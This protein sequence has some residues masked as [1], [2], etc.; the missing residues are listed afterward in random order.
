MWGG[1]FGIKK[2]KV[3]G[4][5]N[6]YVYPKDQF[7][8]TLYLN[9]K[10]VSEDDLTYLDNLKKEYGTKT[11]TTTTTEVET[12]AATTTTT[13]EKNGKIQEDYTLK[14]V[15][16][17]HL[18]W[19]GYASEDHFLGFITGY[20][21]PVEYI[22]ALI[23]EGMTTAPD[24]KN[25][26]ST[27]LMAVKNDRNTILDWAFTYGFF[28]EW[29]KVYPEKVAEYFARFV[30]ENGAKGGG[31]NFDFN[32]LPAKL[33]REHPDLIKSI[34]ITKAYTA[35]GDTADNWF[36]NEEG[37]NDS[38]GI[39]N[40]A[41]SNSS[42]SSSNFK[43]TFDED[44]FVDI[45][46]GN[47]A[48]SDDD[49]A[50]DD[51]T[52]KTSALLLYFTMTLYEPDDV[53]QEW[54][55]FIC[56]CDHTLKFMTYT[57][58]RAY[59]KYYEPK[60]A[61]YR[62]PKGLETAETVDGK[63]AYF[64]DC[65]YWNIGDDSIYK[66]LNGRMDLKPGH[67][68]ERAEIVLDNF[69]KF[70]YETYSMDA[71]QG[72]IKNEDKKKD[73]TDYVLLNPEDEDDCEP[74]GTY[75]IYK[76]TQTCNVLPGS[77]ST[78]ANI[79]VSA[80]GY[81]WKKTDMKMV[82]LEGDQDQYYLENATLRYRSPRDSNHKEVMIARQGLYETKYN[83]TTGK[84][85]KID[86]AEEVT[87]F[88][89]LDRQNTPDQSYGW[90]EEPLAPQVD[91]F[92]NVTWTVPTTSG[93]MATNHTTRVK[94]GTFYIVQDW[95]DGREMPQDLI[96]PTTSGLDEVPILDR[97]EKCKATQTF[98]IDADRNLRMSNYRYMP[99]YA[100][101]P[102]TIFINPKTMKPF[103]PNA[104]SF[105]RQNGQL[106]EGNLTIIKQN[107]IYYK[108]TRSIAP[109]YTTL[110]HR[111][112]VDA[113][114]YPGTFRLVGETR[115]RER[116]TG[117][118]MRYQFEIPLCKMSSDTSLTLEAA[119]DPTTFTMTM[120]VLRKDDGTM[121]K[122]T[123]YDVSNSVYDGYKSDSTEPVPVPGNNED[124]YDIYADTIREYELKIEQ[125]ED[126]TTY[127][128]SPEHTEQVV[129]PQVAL[130]KNKNSIKQI[131]NTNTLQ[132]VEDDSTGWQTE[133]R[134]VLDKNDYTKTITEVK[135]K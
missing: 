82:S 126:G 58:N 22:N 15:W 114:H 117:K 27:V 24:G 112:T 113:K 70:E 40:E 9:K 39:V 67:R 95:N 10:V 63:V 121:M 45:S 125:P 38:N 129:T 103:E 75:C 64:V 21:D 76:Q 94:V 132:I 119:G 134:E 71:K 1:K 66:Q 80:Y 65:Y 131:Y 99:E 52:K 54:I 61:K 89:T 62:C 98:C 14:G 11:E 34:V 49:D 25:K 91:F 106:V 50:E 74:F 118:D 123:Q 8:R 26:M 90:F 96:H 41:T 116:S 78:E 84:W 108:W 128:M 33:L 115:A 105:V 32:K 68:P 28:S 7:G 19:G 42:S 72:Y 43:P 86:N 110:G 23:K 87:D 48:S 29:L 92:I 135:G 81:N 97:M 83:T 124:E 104:G 2:S 60:P 35:K 30:R 111:V 69:G 47:D 13:T 101:T 44:T 12:V 37:G 16:G 59:Y 93:D 5:W 122:L 4:L 120:K 73:E 109:V 100:V 57:P 130:Y 6:P 53:R 88:T 18:S 133:N 55:K 107:E 20:Y 51:D 31:Y 127:I 79:N 102:L 85:E 77:E 3:Q 46:S 56:P 36:E 17:L